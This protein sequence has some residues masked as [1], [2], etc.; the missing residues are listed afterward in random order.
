MNSITTD[1]DRLRSSLDQLIAQSAELHSALINERAALRANDLT[2]LASAVAAKQS[3]LATIHR[4]TTELGPIPLSQ[5][6]NALP[7]EHYPE[8]ERR[9]SLL[10]QQ[11][12]NAKEY[13]AVNGKI[14][15]RSQQS[16]QALIQLTSGVADEL[17]YSERGETQGTP[18]GTSFA[19]A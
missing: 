4:L 11:A 10:L 8:L 18:G 16:V 3:A 9:H 19:Q 14:I 15:Q 12:T 2:A 5:R 13:N 7:A 6:I 17:I 1:I